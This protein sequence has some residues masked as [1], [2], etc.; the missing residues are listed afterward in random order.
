MKYIRLRGQATIVL[1]PDWMSHKDMAR[2]R[3]VSSAGFVDTENWTC[4]GE[5]ISLGIKSQP[6]VDTPILKTML[7]PL[8]EVA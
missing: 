2:D 3:F 7:K 1:F 6:G 5:S 8:G 4:Y